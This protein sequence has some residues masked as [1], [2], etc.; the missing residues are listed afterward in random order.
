MLMW[1]TRH[2]VS[3]S[4]FRILLYIIIHISY[5]LRIHILTKYI[6]NEYILNIYF[7]IYNIIFV[8][9]ACKGAHLHSISVMCFW[10]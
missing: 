5:I 3:A 7:I 10:L 4:I 8:S 1:I 2:K 6:F 9:L